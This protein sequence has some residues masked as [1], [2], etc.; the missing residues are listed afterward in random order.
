MMERVTKKQSQPAREFAEEII[1]YIRE[2]IGDKYKFDKR[3]V[4]S[5]KYNTVIKDKNGFWDIDYQLL[6]TKNSKEYKRNG[7]SSA[8]K[9]K[10]DFFNCLNDE[11]NSN[12]DYKVENST[13][14]VTFID[15]KNKFSIDFVIIRLVPTNHEIIRRNNKK[16]SSINEYTWN[17][18]RKFND[19]YI[20][21]NELSPKKKQDCLENHI[22]PRKVIEK[23]KN[24]NDPTKLSSCEAFVVEVNN[25]VAKK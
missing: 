5:V 14:A 23:A 8:T 22:L 16:N 19:A 11:F 10:E 2:Q 4:G 13:T 21:F 9:I 15:K 25:Y 12:K 3:I 20:K 1:D 6:L 17:E 18:L 7:L 24:D